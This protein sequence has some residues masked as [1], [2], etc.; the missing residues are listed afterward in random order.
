MKK[1]VGFV[2]TAGHLDIEWYQ[3]LRS[4]RF[5][6]VEAIENL[7]LAAKR[8]DFKTYVLD[9]QF[10][11]LE[12]YLDVLPMEK[13]SIEKLIEEGKLSIGP[14]Y[15]QFD[16]WLPSAESMIRNCLIGK[17]RC[18]EF[19]Q[20][21]CAGYLPDN[22]GH[23]R[24][25]PQI[26]NGFGINS[27]LFMRGMPEIVE[28][29]SDEFIYEGIDGSEVL[30][31][32]FRESYSGA[33]DIYKKP[34]TPIQPR[35]VPY[36][37]DYLSFEWH[38]EIADHNTPVETAKNMVENVQRI[39]VNYPSQVIPLI[40]GYDHLPPQI[41]IGDTLKVAN[42]MQD[43]IE[44]I[45]GSVEDY[46]KM[47][48]E[49]IDNP[50]RYSM[51]LLGSKYQ[52]VL[53][54][55]LSTRTYLKRQNFACEALLERYAEP[56][57]VL[58][59]TIGYCNR[60]TLLQEAWKELLLNSAH[61]SI[62]GSSVDEVHVEME[63]RFG[64]TRQ[65]A[66]GI[67]HETM[68]Y[69]GK[70]H[71]RWWGSAQNQGVLVYAPI[72]TNT[73]QRMEVWLPI[74]DKQIVMQAKDGTILPTQVMDREVIEKNGIGKARN[75]WFPAQ[76]YRKVSFLS[77][78]GTGIDSYKVVECGEP[79]VNSLMAGENYIE[80]KF[81]R[82]DVKNNLLSILDKETGREY[83]NLNLIQEDADAGDAWDYSP[84]W[85]PGKV[86]K[87]TEFQFRSKL[88]MSGTVFATL[89][90]DGVLHVPK[91]LKGDLRSEEY[92]EMPITFEVTVT[93]DTPRVDVKCIFENYAKDHRVR[94]HVPTGIKSDYVRSQGHLAIIDREIECAKEVTKWWQPPTRLMPCREWVSVS[95]MKEGLAIGIK[96]LYDYEAEVNPLTR[97]VELM[98]TLVR[99]FD[100]MGRL[101]TM[102]REG[103]ASKAI[104][105]PD[106]Q[107]LGRQEIEWSYIPFSTQ[108]DE[109]APFISEVQKFLYPPVVHAV[110]STEEEVLT[111][112]V[113]G[114]GIWTENNI[115]FSA[116]KK[117]YEEDAYIVRFYENQGISKPVEI[118]IGDF[119]EVH[120]CNLDERP[121]EDIEVKDGKIL[122]EIG[123][124][125]VITVML[126]K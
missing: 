32:H 41:N 65:I 77:Q 89:E 48:Y 58:S 5:W 114:I 85:I 119:S 78:V 29:H 66:A 7:K 125:K 81:I 115:Q 112:S 124:Y 3:P 116:L 83:H 63:A 64:A 1:K 96:G 16:E 74:E 36:Y 56:L 75:D 91:C 103:Y 67:I 50:E 100:L 35:E 9:G 39:A 107:C 72:H 88:K 57:T 52:Y 45:M 108:S 98:F 109:K 18:Q 68:E 44:F 71:R 79:V 111:D 22:F 123:A 120:L 17:R 106:A 6:T 86:V 104:Y 27:L 84:S 93:N 105:T 69:I 37:A 14:F 97:E 46:I 94:L 70:H 42:E 24:Q 11:P 126:K 80:N 21:M 59:E 2:I 47:V 13:D 8:D 92:C 95:D 122:V 101:N 43:D 4:Y 90:V 117:N 73:K 30:V 54:G 62:H 33:F 15:T 121:L 61:D 110:R 49:K 99:G 118:F 31:S 55:A 19:G 26:L 28:G 51:E 60:P 20:W 10:Y 113:E 76:V 34:V 53:L 40:A 82:V 23:P 25:L 38:K 12:E 87:S 102:Q